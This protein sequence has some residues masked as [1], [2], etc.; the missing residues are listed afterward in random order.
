VNFDPE[1]LWSDAPRPGVESTFDSEFRS[2]YPRIFGDFTIEPFEEEWY[3]VS[4]R[5]VEQWTDGSVTWVGTVEGYEHAE[6]IVATTDES[7]FGIL[8][9]GPVVYELRA[10]SDG[11]AYIHEPDIASYGLES[12]CK[13]GLTSVD[14]RNGRNAITRTTADDLHANPA[15]LSGGSTSVIDILLLYSSAAASNYDIA[16]LA[17]LV[18]CIYEYHF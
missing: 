11:N 1:A 17:K 10:G 18:D 9:V 8:R 13:Q 15:P 2:T 12:A 3:V 4:G 14:F 5:Y 16:A 6:F 7:Y